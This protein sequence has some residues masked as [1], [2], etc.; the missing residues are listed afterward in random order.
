MWKKDIIKKMINY[1][2]FGG[3]LIITSIALINFI[4]TRKA[5]FTVA[6]DNYWIGFY[7]SVLSGVI[8]FAGV[9]LTIRYYINRDRKAERLK[10]RPYIILSSKEPNF[11]EAKNNR[12]NYFI[13]DKFKR[14]MK[15]EF[16]MIGIKMNL[17]NIG[18]GPAIEL[19]LDRLEKERIINDN[20]KKYYLKKGDEQS[21]D[22]I[23]THNNEIKF[24]ELVIVYADIEDNIYEQK[25][26]LK[27]NGIA[28]PMTL[29]EISSPILVISS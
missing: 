16:S 7:G 21:I 19:R 4:I 9:L 3:L 26:T 28:N 18:N 29:H 20:S 13:E 8:T 6:K 24:Y 25:I 12:Y 2:F 22:L 11:F 5:I 1:V 14:E 10:I 15:K 23:C 17:E 27:N